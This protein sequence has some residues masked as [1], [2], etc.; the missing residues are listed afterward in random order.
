[1][2][3]LESNIIIYA[4]DPEDE[5]LSISLEAKQFAIS[6]IEVLGY[7]QITSEELSSSTR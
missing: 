5:W 4:T 7:H 6:Q 2:R 3:L 1:M